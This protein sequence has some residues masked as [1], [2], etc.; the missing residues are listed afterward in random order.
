MPMLLLCPHSTGQHSP[1]EN[2]HSSVYY[3][4]FWTLYS[5]PRTWCKCCEDL[6]KTNQRTN[7]TVMSDHMNLTSPERAWFSLDPHLSSQ[8]QGT[9]SNLSFPCA[10]CSLRTRLTDCILFNTRSLQRK[11]Q[12]I[13]SSDDR[14][15]ETP[16]L[17]FLDI[18]WDFLE[19]EI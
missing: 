11:G 6:G 1:Y 9:L 3:K 16:L 17:K 8:A 19:Q 5:L 4:C 2:L 14:P 15:K 10:Y 7:Q 13:T 12:S 18:V